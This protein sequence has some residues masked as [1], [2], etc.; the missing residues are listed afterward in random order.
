MARARAKDA[1]V[2]KE[3][4]AEAEVEGS[5]EMEQDS[6][7]TEAGL[8][9]ID[10]DDLD[11]VIS[12]DDMSSE[13]KDE[14]RKDI[15]NLRDQI[16]E[17]YFELAEKLWIVYDKGL[18]VDWSYDSWKDYVDKELQ[19]GLRKAQYLVS[20]VNYFKNVLGEAGDEVRKKVQ[21]LGWSK[22]KELVGVVKPNN[23]DEWVAD[24]EKLNAIEVA[25]KARAFLSDK[26]DSGKDVGEEGEKKLSKSIA[27]KF[28]PDQMANVEAALKRAGELT[29]SEHKPGN[30]DMICT[31]FLATNDFMSDGKGA[32]ETW[33]AKFEEKLGVKLVAIDPIKEEIIYG[34]DVLEQFQVSEE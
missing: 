17:G 5:E 7:E 34:E 14:I 11:Q 30:L 22:V 20:I 29:G 18:Y 19:F 9:V 15:I 21:H 23:V 12:E 16:D 1:K 13:Q 8:K 2:V 6:S 25:D 24:C 27:F 33:F 3:V 26:S 28:P 31:D 32:I 4:E 10:D